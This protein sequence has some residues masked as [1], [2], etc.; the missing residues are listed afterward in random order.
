MTEVKNVFTAEV[1]EIAEE[2]RDI[3]WLRILRHS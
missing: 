1:A 3:E 2:D